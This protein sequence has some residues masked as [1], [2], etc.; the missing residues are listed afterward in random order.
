MATVNAL[1]CK[2][3]EN[4]NKMHFTQCLAGMQVLGMFKHHLTELM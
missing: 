1:K 3:L 2:H 4:D